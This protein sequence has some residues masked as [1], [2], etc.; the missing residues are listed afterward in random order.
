MSDFMTIEVV[1]AVIVHNDKILAAKRPFNKN[2]GG[3]WEFPGGK[4]EDGESEISA[5]KREIRE[6]LQCEIEVGKFIVNEVYEYDFAIISLSTFICTL[7]NDQPEMREHA[8]LRWLHI[9]EL[10]SV[11]WAPA[12]YA[13]LDILKYNKLKV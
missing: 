10:D 13:T 5:L 11:E 8:E 12:D 9:S 7:K 2:L 3:Y 1:G 4:V 6:E